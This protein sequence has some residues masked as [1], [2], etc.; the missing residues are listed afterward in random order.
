M[1]FHYVSEEESTIRE[2]IDG[3]VERITVQA[4]TYQTQGRYK[5]AE[6]LY[7]QVEAASAPRGPCDDSLL[8]PEPDLV[9]LYEKLGNLPAAEILQERRL[10]LLMTFEHPSEEAV[11]SREADNLFR[12]YT[13][14]LSR[15]EDLHIMPDVALLSTFYRI[16]VLDCSLLNTLLFQSELWTRCN[17]ELC[18]QI[19]IRIKSTEMIRGLISI[20]TDINKGAVSWSPPLLSAAQY[21]NLEGLELLL[22]NNVDVGAL[23]SNSETALHH[24]VLRDAKQR[25]E[26][27]EIIC[28]LAEAGVN[29]N[30]VDIYSR[31]A[32]HSPLVHIRTEPE[33]RVVRCLIETGV[34]IEAEDRNQ[35]TALN[36]AVRRGYLTT[37]RL[38]LLQGANTEVHGR[39]GETPLSCA[40]RYADK[41]MIKLLLDHGANI[42]AQDG[43]GN[44]P[45]HDAVIS[46]Q[47]EMVRMWLGRGAS[48]ATYNEGGQTPVDI[49]RSK[50]NQILLDILSGLDN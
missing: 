29:I 45:L 35:E 39:M 28:R 49:A 42:E 41:S 10:I 26:T 27:Y 38:L 23:G 9:L 30:A 16:A 20:G 32:L 7:R 33:E 22:E 43:T 4:Q 2:R 34:D 13:Y 40:G 1:H 5:D 31:T 8:D 15:C 21:G 18:L 36:L 12:L 14:F 47:V 46:G 25:D 44:T 19:A 6:Y 48:V 24:A 11:I 3:C 37:V 17:P 50:G